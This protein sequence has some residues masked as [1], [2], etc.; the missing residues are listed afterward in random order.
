MSVLEYIR[1]LQYCDFDSFNN[2]ID[3]KCSVSY[4]FNGHN[5]ECDG[6][7][8]VSLLKK[9]HFENTFKTELLKLTIEKTLIPDQYNIIDET[10]YHRKGLGRDENGPGEY[11]MRSEGVV[12]F[13]NKKIV[14]IEYNF[15]KNKIK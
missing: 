15:I 13:S 10:I 11:K 8:F 12:T 9:G 3:P 1:S 5:N 7:T 2:L 4:K 14:K 6:E